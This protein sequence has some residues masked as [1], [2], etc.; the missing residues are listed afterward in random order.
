MMFQPFDEVSDPFDIPGDIEEVV[1]LLLVDLPLRDRVILAGLAEAD[2]DYLYVA[3]TKEITKEFRL[4]GG[5]PELLASC[6][7][8][9]LTHDYDLDDP[10][11]IIVRALWEDI[12]NTHMLRIVK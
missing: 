5:N 6:R 3:M 7:D 2:L 8:F 4:P 12:K 1:D 9:A 10:V 11:M